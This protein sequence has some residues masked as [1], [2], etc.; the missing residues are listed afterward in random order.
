MKSISHY[1]VK[2]VAPIIFAAASFAYA[3]NVYEYMPATPASIANMNNNLYWKVNG[4]DA[5]ETKPED[6]ASLLFTDD[7]LAANGGKDVQMYFLRKDLTLT[8]YTLSAASNTFWL[9]Y[10]SGDSAIAANTLSIEGTLNKSGNS[11]LYLGRWMSSSIST[12]NNLL[13]ININNLNISEGTTNIIGSQ[14]ILIKNLGTSKVTGGTLKVDANYID[15]ETKEGG[16]LELWGNLD[17]S[18]K[19]SVNLKAKTT[20]I[21]SVN[22]QEGALLTFDKTNDAEKNIINA[23]NLSISTTQTGKGVIKTTGNAELNVDTLR[24]DAQN[25]VL[26]AYGKTD[27]KNVIVSDKYERG[28]GHLYFYQEDGKVGN[29][30]VV[31]GSI[32]INVK[33]ETTKLTVDTLDLGNSVKKN[34]FY[35]G[36][37]MQ[38][39]YIGEIKGTTGYFIVSR[40]TTDTT[41]TVG[42]ISGSFDNVAPWITTTVENPVTVTL[43]IDSDGRDFKYTGIVKDEFVNNADR[44]SLA[45][46]KNGTSRQILAGKNNFTGG[47]TVNKGTLHANS[48]TD[49]VIGSVTVNK[50]GYFGSAGTFVKVDSLIMNGGKLLFDREF[51]D[52]IALTFNDSSSISQ[53]LASD[54]AFANISDDML[55][56]PF[57]LI[58][59]DDYESG[60]GTLLQSIIDSED[61]GKYTYV[62]AKTGKTYNALFGS[63]I[64]SG[65]FSVT[66]SVPEP[67]TWAAIFGA[68]ALAFAI[69]RK[70]QSK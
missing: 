42:G 50:G 37:N 9:N 12:N 43:K 27:I 68:L 49:G 19:S 28:S 6:G 35:L 55:D 25:A 36:G 10:F 22:V 3:E 57:S 41:T 21:S 54:F 16:N 59:F 65:V 63:E 56:K 23:E 67:S 2:V 34:A 26:E 45:I 66:L 69:Y 39:A 17:I 47:L 4:A 48:A 1:T 11:T 40:E 64:D 60:I 13:N 29:I 44:A 18:G 15:S 31:N 38:N 46:V 8:D 7:T 5:T 58:E 14:N 62:D 24:L 51:G 61:N 53:I 52:S 33:N 20:T 32:W 70:R 30:S